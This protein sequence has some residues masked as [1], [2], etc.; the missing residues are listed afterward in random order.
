[1][2][3]TMPNPNTIRQD[4]DSRMYSKTSRRPSRETEF[5]SP[6][7][8]AQNVWQHS[9]GYD[10]A[11]R[12][13]SKSS[14]DVRQDLFRE[15][16]FCTSDSSTRDLLNRDRL[17]RLA[18]S[19]SDDSN[20]HSV[21]S[22]DSKS[23]MAKRIGYGTVLH[24]EICNHRHAREMMINQLQD[25]SNKADDSS[26]EQTNDELLET[27]LAQ[28]ELSR[29]TP[30]SSHGLTSQTVESPDQLPP[31][32][33]L[34]SEHDA[35]S[36]NIINNISKEESFRLNTLHSGNHP[37]TEGSSELFLS[38][39]YETSPLH[40]GTDMRR[41]SYKAANETVDPPPPAPSASRHP[42][43]KEASVDGGISSN[44]LLKLMLRMFCSLSQHVETLDTYFDQCL[45]GEAE[46]LHEE[47]GR[48]LQEPLYRLDQLQAKMQHLESRLLLLEAEQQVSS[49]ILRLVIF[50]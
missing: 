9:S 40:S 15:T 41:N 24:G 16:S 50:V 39:N 29:K 12:M 8:G 45:R 47:I 33:L 18:R 14:G 42:V 38:G 36:V 32:L 28:A 43:D 4:Y 35:E 11:Q 19:D 31:P 6:R 46:R 20:K 22:K 34:L 23:S 49:L 7:P 37:A 2:Y 1:M 17:G 44:L 25:I 27:V 13:F 30:S 3:K 21:S 5:S 26:N 48:R 10:S